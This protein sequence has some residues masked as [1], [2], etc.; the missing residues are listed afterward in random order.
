MQILIFSP[1]PDIQC[2][3]ACHFSFLHH[4]QFAISPVGGVGVGGD[5]P[6]YEC[7]MCMDMYIF[8]LE[9]RAKN[10]CFQN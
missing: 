7:Y 6:E 8:Q 10:L 4:L 2:N 5:W 3:I 1:T 9:N